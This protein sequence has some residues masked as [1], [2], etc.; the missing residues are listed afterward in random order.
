MPRSH[1]RYSL[2]RTSTNPG[3]GHCGRHDC[4]GRGLDGRGCKHPN[5][6]C[7]ETVIARGR[8][9]VPGKDGYFEPAFHAGV[10]A[11]HLNADGTMDFFDRELL[12][13][14]ER[15]TCVGQLH[16]PLPGIAGKR[17]DGS[18]IKVQAV[19]PSKLRVGANLRV[20][21]DGRVYT[22]K[23]GVVMY[24]PEQSLELVEHH[25]HVA[26]RGP[27]AQAAP[28]PLP[29]RAAARPAT[30]RWDPHHQRHHSGVVS[31]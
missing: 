20:G 29:A 15:D 9:A 23:A 6:S 17:L 31:G 7:G 25:I 27:L 1:G 3:T 10:Q 19:R 21:G 2:N 18:E 30:L 5:Y 14:F 16:S 12:K 13:S 11:G 8:A 4:D 26:Q 28:D 22:S 24:V